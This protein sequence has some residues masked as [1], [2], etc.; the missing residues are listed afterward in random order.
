MAFIISSPIESIPPLLYVTTCS[1]TVTFFFVSLSS[2]FSLHYID[3]SVSSGPLKI[4]TRDNT[5]RSHTLCICLSHSLPKSLGNIAQSTKSPSGPLPLS[6]STAC[7]AG[8]V[9]FVCVVRLHCTLSILWLDDS[10]AC[11]YLVRQS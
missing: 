6:C 9:D 4:I 7:S 8:R 5:A 11:S 1:L 10:C 2:N 3:L